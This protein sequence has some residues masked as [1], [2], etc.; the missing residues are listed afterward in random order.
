AAGPRSISGLPPG[1]RAIPVQNETEPEAAAPAPPP[2]TA[3]DFA[4]ESI[5]PR[6][7]YGIALPILSGAQPAHPAARPTV[8]AFAAQRPWLKVLT[9]AAGVTEFVAGVLV[10]IGLLTRFASFSLFCVM[11]VAIWLASIG[12]IV[13]GGPDTPSWLGFLP[14]LNNFQAWQSLMFQFAMLMVSL[15]M[16]F[17][18]PGVL[19]FD[20]GIFSSGRRK[21]AE[22]LDD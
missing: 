14:P 5:P 19:S 22:S 21:H 15:A 6:G 4:A 11:V 7:V 9:W 1:V 3:D 2:Y 20:S 10:L 12:P 13:F 8:P 18:R 16:V 17:G